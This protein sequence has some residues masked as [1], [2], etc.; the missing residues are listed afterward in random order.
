VCSGGRRGNVKRG[1]SA[2]G[3]S[4]G[5]KKVESDL[6]RSREAFPRVR[7]IAHKGRTIT[8]VL[9]CAAWTGVIV[10]LR[11]HGKRANNRSGRC[12]RSLP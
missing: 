11:A 1:L 7:S 6:N 2:Q 5:G 8:L 10:R 4:V 12:N 3:K 9:R